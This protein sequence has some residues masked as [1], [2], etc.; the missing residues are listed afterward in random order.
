MRFSGEKPAREW[1]PRVQGR[2]SKQCISRSG[3]ERQRDRETETETDRE[4]DRQEEEEEEKRQKM[5]E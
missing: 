3:R 1:A 5:E 4:T 2:G